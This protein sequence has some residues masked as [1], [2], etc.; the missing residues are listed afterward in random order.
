MRR[1]MMMVL[2]AA[3]LGLLL[4]GTA[5]P[6]IR[7]AVVVWLKAQETAVVNCRGD[8]LIITPYGDNQAEIVCREW[9]Q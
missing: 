9:V 5:R 8:E 3:G 2:I 1:R 6:P 4:L 7:A